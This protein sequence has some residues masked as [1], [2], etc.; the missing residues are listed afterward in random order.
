MALFNIIGSIF[1]PS[2]T[3]STYTPVNYSPKENSSGRAQKGKLSKLDIGTP[4][5]FKHV[6]HVGFN[7]MSGLDLDS[8]VD[9][10]ALISLAG[11]QGDVDKESSHKIFDVLKKEAPTE[12]VQKMTRRKTSVEKPNTRNRLR[13]LSSSSITPTK[14]RKSPIKQSAYA[15][16][17]LTPLRDQIPINYSQSL[18]KVPPSS[19]VSSSSH[20]PSMRR[21]P[22]LPPYLKELSETL[23]CASSVHH[24]AKDKPVL[25]PHPHFLQGRHSK[26][27]THH[28]ISP[29][30]ESPQ[31]MVTYSLPTSNLKHAAAE[32]ES[33]QPQHPFPQFE[34]D[35]TGAHSPSIPTMESSV[36][37]YGDVP[38]LP[39]PPSFDKGIDSEIVMPSS[40]CSEPLNTEF[41]HGTNGTIPPAPALPFKLQL[42][43]SQTLHCSN[44][45]FMCKSLDPPL[46]AQTEPPKDDCALDE[47]EDSGDIISQQSEQ[48]LFLDQI[49][50]GV[51]LKSV[52][53]NSRSAK[54]ESSECSS[55]ASALKA[56][57]Q[58][59]HKAM[60]SS[61]DED[62]VEEEWED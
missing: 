56:V 11:V 37:K 25:P 53:Q 4:N 54:A 2:E 38:P 59:R 15:S 52:S 31:E 43:S 5:N 62:E 33:L 22:P 34:K 39:F 16:K 26:H 10:K 13:S 17:S 36:L 57:I 60:H 12:H 35:F 61:D 44:E 28:P 21:P 8:D 1:Q 9:M 58:R 32:M 47:L 42:G 46:N 49:K 3:R 23:S 18:S 45:Q 30:K 55:I 20:F 19:S 27:I 41:A 7:S 6:T 24:Q 29:S 50:Q 40:L 14:K 51:Q 48:T